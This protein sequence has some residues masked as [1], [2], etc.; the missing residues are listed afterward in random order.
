M[1]RGWMHD[2]WRG[3][4]RE[5]GEVREV[6]CMIGGWV[7]GRRWGSLKKVAIKEAGST[8]GKG[9]V[10][11]TEVGL[12]WPHTAVNLQKRNI[13]LNQFFSSLSNVLTANISKIHSKIL[14]WQGVSWKN[15]EKRISRAQSCGDEFSH[16][17][18][19]PIIVSQTYLPH[20]CSSGDISKAFCKCE[21][22]NLIL[23]MCKNKIYPMF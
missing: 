22:K 16:Q 5:V 14:K 1:W 12:V 15:A 6:G 23:S 13:S 21:K 7:V 4:E 11:S 10:T 20:L 2:L 17:G 3:R 19:C 18:G 8:L 9:W